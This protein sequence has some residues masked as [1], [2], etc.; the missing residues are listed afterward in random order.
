MECPTCGE[1]GDLMRASIKKTGQQVMVCT[2]CDFLWLHP[3]Q[4]I[5]PARATDVESFLAQAGLASN[6]DELIR[7][8]RL[9]PPST[10]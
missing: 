2:E 8:A 5:D 6:W 4:A 7:G 3:E 1:Y 9:P 10:A